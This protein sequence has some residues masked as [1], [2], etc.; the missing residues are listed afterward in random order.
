[1]RCGPS[2]AL[3]A[4]ASGGLPWQPEARV[5]LTAIDA[6][7]VY[8]P[9]MRTRILAIAVCLCAAIAAAAQ[10]KETKQP[11]VAEARTFLDSASAELL[12]LNTDSA[13]AQWISETYI[14]PD[15]ANNVALVNGQQ[16]ARTL[17]LIDASH[18]FDH[19]KLPADLT[20]QMQLL[21]LNATAAPKDP[22]LL[23]E[24]AQLAAELTGMYGKGKFCPDGNDAKCMG[25]DEI[26]TAM[27]RS[28]DPEEL[29]KLWVGWHAVGAPMRAKYTRFIEL[30]NI[31]ARELGYHDTGEFW[32]AG[33][34]MTPAEFDT[35]VER[36]WEQLKPLY[37]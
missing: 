5:S 12:K 18:R 31:G 6:K 26:S 29:T 24:Q 32:R 19:I 21:K 1:M 13:H 9:A 3:I 10:S 33:Y 7:P 16:T 25:I 27:A 22:A 8:T 11:T 17:A 35:E 36:A 14:T 15:T 23:A 20:R 28:R 34:D 2:R 37:D 30:Q 4:R